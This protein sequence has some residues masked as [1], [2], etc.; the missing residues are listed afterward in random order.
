MTSVARSWEL[1]RDNINHNESEGLPQLA[2]FV[3]ALLEPG[4]CISTFVGVCRVKLFCFPF[5]Y[6]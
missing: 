5:I 1:L 2:A 4:R 6:E 3:F